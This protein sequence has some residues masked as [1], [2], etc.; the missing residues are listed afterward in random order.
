MPLHRNLPFATYQCLP[1][2]NWSRLKLLARSPLHF[3]SPPPV[4]SDPLFSALHTALLE[5]QIFAEQ[6][7][8]AEGRRTAA[9]KAAAGDRVLLTARDFATIQ[10]VV[11]ALHAH[12]V[13]GALLAEPGWSELTMTWEDHGRALKGRID[14]LTSSGTLIDL[15]AVPSVEPRKIAVEVARRLY[16]G[17]LAHYVE[18]L[19]ACGQHGERVVVIAYEAAPPYDV[20]VY[21]LELDAALYVG[22]VLRAGLLDVLA[23][24]EAEDRWPGAAPELRP[25]VL[26]RWAPGIEQTGVDSLADEDDHL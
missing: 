6:Y 7:Q 20:G 21:A 11:D 25:L 8:L 23:Q 10:G 4:D 5:P 9:A 15:K 2:L 3:R 18:G 22:E 13:A 1:G 19:R 26:P 24:C 12:P 14:R 16:H 17:Q